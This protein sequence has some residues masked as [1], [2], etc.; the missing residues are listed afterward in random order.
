MIGAATAAAEKGLS[1]EEVKLAGRWKSS[2]FQTYI[3]SPCSKY[4]LQG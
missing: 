2:E 4:I 3:K 1:D